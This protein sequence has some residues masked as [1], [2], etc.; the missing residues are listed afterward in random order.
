MVDEGFEHEQ[1]PEARTRTKGGSDKNN[2]EAKTLENIKG[3][4]ALTN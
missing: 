4:L 1:D 3:M 2:C